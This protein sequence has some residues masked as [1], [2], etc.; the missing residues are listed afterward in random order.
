MKFIKDVLA[1]LTALLTIFALL[2]AGF[3]FLGVVYV[4]VGSPLA[5]FWTILGYSASAALLI[6]AAHWMVTHK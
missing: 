3:F 2:V 4:A 6:T 5:F 1:T